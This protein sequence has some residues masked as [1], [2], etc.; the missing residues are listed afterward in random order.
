MMAVYLLDC[1]STGVVG[2]YAN[3]EESSG[4]ATFMQA[5][6]RTAM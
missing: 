6:E 4:E 1:P 3:Q 5:R 2:R